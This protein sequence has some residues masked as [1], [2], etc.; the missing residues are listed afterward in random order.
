MQPRWL[1]RNYSIINLSQKSPFYLASVL[2]QLEVEYDYDFTLLGISCHEKE[3]RLCWQLNRTFGFE[4]QR[5]ESIVFDKDGP[6]FPLFTFLQEE[7]NS[8]SVI[9]NRVSGG[10]LIP[11]LAQV[12]YFFRADESFELPLDFTERLRLLSW[13]NAVFEL[14]A[15][16]LASRQN[17]L[18]E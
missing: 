17:L 1:A 16:K 5:Q 7:P 9:K 12:D 15:E 14:D 11:E 6:E 8:C 2:H 13:I 10:L 18:L 4:L 3:Y